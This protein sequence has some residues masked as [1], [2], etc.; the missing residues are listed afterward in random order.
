MDMTPIDLLAVGEYYKKDAEQTY[1]KL[2]ENAEDFLAGKN[3]ADGT[4]SLESKL[5]GG[6]YRYGKTR[7]KSVVE[8]NV[9]DDEALAEWLEGNH[10]AALRYAMLNGADFGQYWFNFTGELPEG[11]SRI[12]CEEPA[13]TTSPKLYKF[14]VNNVKE[15]LGIEQS[16][17]EQLLGNP[18]KL[19]GDGR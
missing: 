12:E 14:D 1:K 9:C 17:G 3:M 8:F 5:F 15:V 18:E 16:F 7:A 6:E 4:T 10:G 19:L 13:R 11:I 2:K